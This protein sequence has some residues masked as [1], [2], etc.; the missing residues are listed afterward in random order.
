MKKLVLI[1]GIMLATTFSFANSEK[2]KNIM[3]DDSKICRYYAI[4]EA[5]QHAEYASTAWQAWYSYYYDACENVL[6]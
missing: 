5:N 6:K 4:M 2:T 1:L 3:D